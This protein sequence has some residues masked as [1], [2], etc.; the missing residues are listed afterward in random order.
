MHN[1][2]K[3]AFDAIHAGQQLK[4]RTRGY[5]A[6]KMR[7]YE[8]PRNHMRVSI[9]AAVACVFLLFIGGAW[10]YLTP[11]TAVSMDINPSI[12]L[13]VN[14]FDRIVSVRAYNED[15]E[16]LADAVSVRFQKISEGVRAILND[17]RIA[18]MLSEDGFMTIA[19]VGENGEQ[20]SRILSEVQACAAGREN[21]QCYAAR[22]EE[23]EQAHEYGFSYGKYREFLELQQL[24]PQITP[25][26]IQGMTMREIREWKEK[27]LSGEEDSQN[28]AV[29]GIG[30]YAAGNGF[31]HG[32]QR[33]TKKENSGDSTQGAGA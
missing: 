19:V 27:L 6:E 25:E 15:G 17:E 16:E 7:N 32:Q 8:N 1:E 28:G 21:I 13:E 29:G 9:F 14:R 11:T 18:S 10:V 33:S 5:V 30:Q 31:Q 23:V 2:L 24:N 12:E 4:D 26:D 22:P 20:S 3:E